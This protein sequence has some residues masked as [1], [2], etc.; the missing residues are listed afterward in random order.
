MERAMV[1][2]SVIVP[3]RSMQECYK[4]NWP[5]GLHHETKIEL[6]SKEQLVSKGKILSA[7]MEL[8][9]IIC[10]AVEKMCQVKKKRKNEKFRT[11]L[12]K[13]YSCKPYYLS[14]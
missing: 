10:R 8:Y 12:R 13:M 4:K 11:K 9:I 5:K 3:S 2:T 6:D 7:F 1:Y 14:A